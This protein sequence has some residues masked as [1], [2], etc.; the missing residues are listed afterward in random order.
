MNVSLSQYLTLKNKF[1][2]LLS[3]IQDELN[4]FLKEKGYITVQ[5]ISYRFEIYNPEVLSISKLLEMNFCF[6]L[7]QDIHDLLRDKIYEKDIK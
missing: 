4:D 3:R 1:D 6:I 2:P 7:N 5:L